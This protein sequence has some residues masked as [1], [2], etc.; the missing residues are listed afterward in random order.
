MSKWKYQGSD[1]TD[2]LEKT[3]KIRKKKRIRKGDRKG[4]TPFELAEEKWN[5][6]KNSD[7]FAA[8]VV[9]VHKRYAFV[10]PEPEKGDI[11]TKDVW[12][13]TVARKFLTSEK[14]ERNLVAVGDRVLCRKAGNDEEDV[15]TDIPRCVILHQSPRD[16][17]L[18][19][20]DPITNTR[21]H[22]LACNIS[23][24]VVMASYLGPKIRWG[25]VDR[26]LVVAEEQGL[27]AVLVF[28]KRDLLERDGTD[29]F[30]VECENQVNNYRSLG[31]EV[32]SI[33]AIDSKDS[34]LIRLRK[35]MAS[36]ITVFSGHSGIGK[37]SLINLFDPE[38]VQEVEENS[39]ISYKG[40]HTTTYASLI[41]LGVG[42]YVV[43]TPGIRSFL[44]EERNSID[45][46]YGFVEFRKRMG[47][48]KFRECRHIDEPGCTILDALNKG[49]IAAL[50]YRSYQNL[51]LG[52]SGREGRKHLDKDEPDFEPE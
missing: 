31:Y 17:Q 20:R 43:D 12:L 41:K 18:S 39:N 24:V 22:T 50:R 44:I 35:M 48:C 26:Y 52:Q 28:N 2:D 27:P 14:M 4:E 33:S 37:S 7:H 23:Q 40:R 49:E 10:S 36:K 15:D 9:E 16:S 13:A 29:A 30:K 45:L 19:R 47:Q 21:S 1:N 11:K 34:E 25:L 42:G 6:D 51:L 3:S 8:R 38:I 32:F 5:L 46:S